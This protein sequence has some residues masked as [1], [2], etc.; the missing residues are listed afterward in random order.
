VLAQPLGVVARFYVLTPL[1]LSVCLGAVEPPR[2]KR[3]PMIDRS[4]NAK[5]FRDEPEIQ[6]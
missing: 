5:H 3:E 4:Q 6:R 2:E 1:G